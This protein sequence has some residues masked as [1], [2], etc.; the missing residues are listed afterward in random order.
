M[1]LKISHW[2]V[3]CSSV[4]VMKTLTQK[5]MLIAL[6]ATFVGWGTIRTMADTVVVQH[7]PWSHDDHGYWDDHH[8]YHH[9]VYYQNH[10][11]YW[12][13]ND[14]GVRLFINVD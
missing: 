5:L 13:T 3:A 12:R 8:A 7:D 14:S 9:F 11:G 2:H 10:H 1:R 6:V 4:F